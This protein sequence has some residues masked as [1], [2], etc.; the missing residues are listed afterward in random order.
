[1]ANV[2]VPEMWS[3]T[4]TINNT[5]LTRN[6]L[7]QLIKMDRIKYTKTGKKYLINA[8]SL[9]DYLNGDPP[10]NNANLTEDN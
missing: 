6:F 7:M 10:Q 4:D 9:C 8:A 5:G 1:M 3:I 2:N